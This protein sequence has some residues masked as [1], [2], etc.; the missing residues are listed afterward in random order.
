MPGGVGRLSGRAKRG[1]KAHAEG[2]D[3][4]GG[5][6]GGEGGVGRPTLKTGSGREAL[7]EVQEG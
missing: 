1:R 3:R 2:R 6:P 7:L 4:S 5:P